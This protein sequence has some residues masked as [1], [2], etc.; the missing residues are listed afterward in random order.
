MSEAEFWTKYFESLHFHTKKYTPTTPSTNSKSF[1]DKV[2][3]AL[4]QADEVDEQELQK[5]WK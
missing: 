2:T 5:G 1:K 3:D 4:V